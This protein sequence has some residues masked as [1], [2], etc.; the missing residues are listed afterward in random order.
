MSASLNISFTIS[1]YGEVYLNKIQ[2]HISFNIIQV[3]IKKKYY[4]NFITP[5]DKVL[6]QMSPSNPFFLFHVFKVFI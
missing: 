4:P 2:D 6:Q 3:E 5:I 1:A